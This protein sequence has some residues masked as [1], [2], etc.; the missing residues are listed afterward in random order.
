MS[1]NDWG[2]PLLGTL[3]G[4]LSIESATWPSGEAPDCKSGHSGSTP[5]VASSMSHRFLISVL[6]ELFFAKPEVG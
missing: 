1:F 4:Y 6:G 2:A 3:W 5:L